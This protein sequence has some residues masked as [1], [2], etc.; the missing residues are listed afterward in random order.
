VG[1]TYDG[2]LTEDPADAELESVLPTPPTS[3]HGVITTVDQGRPEEQGEDASTV[4]PDI[5]W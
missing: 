5:R 1:R 2:W 4:D 3:T